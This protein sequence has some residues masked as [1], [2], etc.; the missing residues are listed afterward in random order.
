MSETV[1]LDIRL[2]A[3]IARVWDALTDA[4]TLSQ[5][6]FFQVE[7]FEPVVG[8]RFQWRSPTGPGW[9]GVIESEVLEV[10]APHRLSYSWVGG[11]ESL[12]VRTTVTWTLSPA[13][14]G[15]TDLHLEQSGFAAEAAQAIGGAHYGWTRMLGQLQD[16]L[17]Q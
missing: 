8:H 15:G 5:W 7:H 10:S 16:W 13:P 1:S 3:P 14:G 17:A 6:T 11:P 9:D 12:V 2:E 4:A